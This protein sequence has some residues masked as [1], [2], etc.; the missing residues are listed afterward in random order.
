M[1][2]AIAGSTFSKAIAL[3]DFRLN[4][5][6]IAATLCENRNKPSCCCHGK[7]FLKKQ[8]Q[9]DEDGSKNNFPFSKDKFDV[10]LFFENT[11]CDHPHAGNIFKMFNSGYLEK[12]YTAPLSPVFHPPG[13]V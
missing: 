13:I 8:L 6:Y 4:E 10:S 9:K 11:D 1:L 7:C 5:K 2:V 3:L 12:K